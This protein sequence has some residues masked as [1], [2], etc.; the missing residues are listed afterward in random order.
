[1]TEKPDLEFLA[2][3]QALADS[4]FPKR[5]S[6]CG[7]VYETV[8][9]FVAETV[10]V[11]QGISGAKASFGDNEEV[12]VELYR[13]CVCGS[14]LMDFFSDRRDHSERGVKRRQKFE[15][16]MQYLIAQGVP[17]VQAR[18]ELLSVLRGGTSQLLQRYIRR[19]AD[20]ADK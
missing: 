4:A 3:L 13:N 17:A 20:K 2:G 11:R 6:Y 10:S 12:I 15:E 9:A 16:L 7:K 14:T 1:M 5:C 18:T 19:P 8:Q